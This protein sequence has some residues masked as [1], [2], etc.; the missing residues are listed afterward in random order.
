M[1]NKRSVKYVY[2]GMIGVISL[3]YLK[4]S[5][6]DNSA[7]HIPPGTAHP[8]CWNKYS[9]L[10]VQLSQDKG[11]HNW[12][13]ASAL[14]DTGVHVTKIW[15]HVPFKDRDSNYV[16]LFIDVEKM[17]SVHKMV[18]KYKQYIIVAFTL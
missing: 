6:D 11:L 8:F 18:C 4:V 15:N 12:S 1:L 2:L 3:F 16:T 10:Q 7:I 9:P 13:S 5:C 14:D 17:T